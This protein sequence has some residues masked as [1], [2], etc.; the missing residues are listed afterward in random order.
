MKLKAILLASLIFYSLSSVSLMSKTPPAIKEI[1]TK[2]C[3]IIKQYAV[4]EIKIAQQTFSATE[5]QNLKQHLERVLRSQTL[6]LNEYEDD[7]VA[8][9]TLSELLGDIKLSDFHGATL[10]KQEEDIILRFLASSIAMDTL[11]S[12][13][14]LS[15]KKIQKIK[16]ILA[17]TLA[18]EQNSLLAQE[19]PI[20]SASPI[21][22][23]SIPTF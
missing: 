21:Q 23:I 7:I 13:K 3:A 15:K 1:L 19:E 10:T 2:H 9:K 16:I 17:K 6:L 22:K 5:L 18:M 8:I 20:K 12:R 14:T 4:V 11:L